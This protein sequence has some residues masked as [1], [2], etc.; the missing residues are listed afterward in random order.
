MATAVTSPP[1]PAT[2]SRI[3]VTLESLLDGGQYYAVINAALPIL[4]SPASPA[5]LAGPA[6]RQRCIQAAL[7]ACK[8][9]VALE[10]AGPARELLID[11]A[12]PLSSIPDFRPVLE[13]LSG[14]PSGRR[15]WREMQARFETNAPRLYE[16]H[17]HLRKHDAQFRDIPRRYELFESADGNLHVSPARTNQTG[18]A[19]R[20]WLPAL[21]DLRRLVADVPL[22]HQ[23]RDMFCAPYLL[24]GDHL[25]ALFR[26]VFDATAKMFLTF[27]PRIYLVEPDAAAVGLTLY[28]AESVDAWCHPRVTICAGDS[29]VEDLSR[30]L[31][32]NPQRGVPTHCLRLPAAGSTFT[33]RLVASVQAFIKRR[34][35]AARCAIARVAGEYHSLPTDHWS[36]RFGGGDGAPLRVLG[37]TSRFTTTLQYSMRDVQAAFRRLGHE[38]HVLIEPTDH[39]L[40]TPQDMIARVDAL[41]PDLIFVIDHHRHRYSDVLPGRVPFVCWIQDRLPHLMT[42]DAGRALGPMDFYIAPACGELVHTYDYPAGQ[43]LT[44]TMATNEEEYSFV[45]LPESELAASRCDFSYVSNQ[46]TPPEAFHRAFLETQLRHESGR[47]IAEYLFERLRREHVHAP[48]RA[49]MTPAMQLIAEAQRDLGLAPASPQ[50]ADQL[51]RN[52]IHRVSE[53]FFRQVALQWVADYCDAVGRSLHLYGNGWDAHPRFARYHRGTAANGRHLRA[54]YQASA[55]NLQIIGT[56]AIHQRLLDGLAAGGFFLIRACPADRL[57]DACRRLRALVERDGI[58]PGQVHV[59]ADV[60][61]VAAARDELSPLLGVRPDRAGLVIRP[62]EWD[63]LRSLEADGYRQIAG[64]VFADYDRVA[65]DTREAFCR[66]ADRLLTGPAERAEIA[67][68][69]RRVVL[70][71]FT[72]TAMVRDL[73][74]MLRRRL[75]CESCKS[76]G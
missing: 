72:Y 70:D 2:E 17:P 20:G 37:V 49:G 73:L 76:S 44:W 38:F 59:A 46:S 56:G 31:E 42:K 15:S 55:V 67:A 33:D 36:S 19:P 58:E 40:P 47:R 8:A 23:P 24:T 75:E 9:Y 51:C 48:E 26:R 53:L 5:G 50:I 12:S 13:S 60:P 27:T 69:M 21:L 3:D 32:A 52:Y 71:R 25:G 43:G 16:A 54:V 30:L 57:R 18:E 11:P 10:M 41:R 39:D 45:R 63:W 4:R 6:A 65:F 74:E 61:D 68:R 1:P 66:L 7:L 22:A 34:D 29:A 28:V 35:S 14:L 64:A 62:V